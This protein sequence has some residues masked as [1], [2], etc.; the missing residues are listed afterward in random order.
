MRK[1]TIQVLTIL[2]VAVLVLTGSFVLEINLPVYAEEG[3]ENPGGGEDPGP[4][5]QTETQ[6]PETQPPETQTQP[7]ET[8]PPET[9]P[10]ETQP[11]ETQPPETEPSETQPPETEP[12]E[13]E[14]DTEPEETETSTEDDDDDDGNKHSTHVSGGGS[15]WV[16]AT[17]ATGSPPLAPIAETTPAPATEAPV[18]ETEAEDDGT[19]PNLDHE[20][21]I[22]GKYGLLEE[23]EPAEELGLEAGVITTNVTFLGLS[24]QGLTAKEGARLIKSVANDVLNKEIITEGENG[25]L[26]VTLAELGITCND[27]SGIQQQLEDTIPEG[28]VLDR[29][30]KAKDLELEPL[31]I[32]LELSGADQEKIL[33]YFIDHTQEWITSPKSA[34]VSFLSGERVVTPSTSGTSYDFTA[35]VEQ[36][37]TDIG[38]MD[39]L[40]CRDPY[41]LDCG[42]TVVEPGLTEKRAETFT[43]LG[44]YTTYYHAP[45]DQIYANREQNLVI[46]SSNMNGRCFAPGARISALTMY[47]DVT[48]ANGYREAGTIMGGQHVDAIGGG[49]C[50]TTTTLYNAVLYAELQIIYRSNHSMASN[51][52]PASRDAMV[53]Y[54]GWDHSSNL[55]D[56]VFSN[57]SSD[58]IFVEAF[59]DKSNCSITVRIIG[60]EDHDPGRSVEYVSEVLSITAPTVNQYID[61]TL[62]NSDAPYAQ[63]YRI[64]GDNA[65]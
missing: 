43:I 27:L 30:M 61:N 36:L 59:V 9:Q 52:V 17:Q 46:S 24:L 12:S 8:Q 64:I 42:E 5:E 56:F 14:S 2:L 33:S 1:K 54:A 15:T 34:T 28:N 49:I 48:A 16:K 41:I 10:S 21:S 23:E 55:Y 40:D 18:E 35:G 26:S 51:Y 62:V 60:H 20:N 3:G 32:T 65:A 4:G 63:I 37:M 58:Y 11:P 19:N 57:N 31:E 6:P 39:I 45:T 38:S 22:A 44:S 47:G 7:P 53:Y 25:Q 13:S 50:Q 29:Y